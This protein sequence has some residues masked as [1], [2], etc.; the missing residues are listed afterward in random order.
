MRTPNLEL[1]FIDSLV[2]RELFFEFLFPV[3]TELCFV[4]N[5]TIFTY[6]IFFAD[7]LK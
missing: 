7:K 5:L 6:A 2:F 4:I 1:G 3:A